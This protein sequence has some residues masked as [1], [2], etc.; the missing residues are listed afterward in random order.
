MADQLVADL[1]PA[2]AAASVEAAQEE[3]RK[4]GTR[5]FARQ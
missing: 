5:F 4:R 2:P 3:P 1:R